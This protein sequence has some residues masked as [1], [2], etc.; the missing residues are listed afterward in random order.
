M[1][2]HG[3][4]PVTPPSSTTIPKTTAIAR[5][6]RDADDG[7][8]RDLRPHELPERHEPAPQ[9]ADGALVAF[10]GRGAGGE[11]Q[12]EERHRQRDPVRLHLRGQHPAAALVLRLPQQDRMRGRLQRG[13]R[14][15]EP[16]ARVAD[17]VA[18]RLHAPA[19]RHAR[20]Q[21]LRPVEA[22]DGELAAE[23]AALAAVQQQLHEHEVRLDEDALELAIQLVDERLHLLRHARRER[24][25][26]GAEDE[27]RAARRRLERADEA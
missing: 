5:A 26:A 13:A 12:R 4:P 7:G 15:R 17:E 2:A 16:D 18:D 21:P 20:E 11:Q 24:A 22:E 19:R 9:A 10:R 1:R 8:E 23:E 27:A 25:L 6:E 14:L 3:S